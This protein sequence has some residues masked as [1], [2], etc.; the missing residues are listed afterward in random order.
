MITGYASINLLQWNPEFLACHLQRAGGYRWAT[1]PTTHTSWP[2]LLQ[3]PV[4]CSTE[5][6]QLWNEVQRIYRH[7]CIQ[8]HE[9][10]CR[11]MGYENPVRTSQE[12]HYVS[13]RELSQ[14]ML[15]KIWGFHGGDY[16]EFRLLG[17][18]NPVR[19]SQETHSYSATEP[20]R[21]MLCKIW[22]FR[23]GDYEEFR[24]L[25]CYAVRLL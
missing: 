14:L 16:E 25:G 4:S 5:Q 20:S 24:L 7:L 10:E 22:A 9:E 13:A 15:C 11:L 2:E 8:E 17:Y 1:V 23:G 12:T 3:W 6:L 19:T 21:L 18:K